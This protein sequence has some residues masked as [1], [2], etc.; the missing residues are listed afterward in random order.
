MQ[1]I[2]NFI[3]KVFYYHVIVY[4]LVTSI[5]NMLLHLM[6]YLLWKRII[7]NLN[8]PPIEEN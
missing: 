4:S 2:F 1:F 8:T 6:I 5:L 3:W 7:N